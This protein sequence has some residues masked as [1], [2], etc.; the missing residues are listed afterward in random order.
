MKEY[1]AKLTDKDGVEWLFEGSI[2]RQPIWTNKNN[3]V[4][5]MKYTKSEALKIAKCHAMKGDVPG[6][7]LVK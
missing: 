5:R 6:V 4:P 2:K 1:N 3:A 7:E